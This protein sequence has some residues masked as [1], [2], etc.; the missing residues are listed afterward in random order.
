[1]IARYISAMTSGIFITLSLF[2]VMQAL[3][4]LTHMDPDPERERWSVDFGR[5]ITERPVQQR[6]PE[7][8]WE[9]LKQAPEPLPPRP[10]HEYQGATTRVNVRQPP[11]PDASDG[12]VP[13][14][15]FSDGP[16]V[17]IVRVQPSYPPRAEQQGLEGWVLVEFDVGSDG[18]VAN[19]R[20]VESS[21][22]LFEK[23]AINAA[24]KFRF[25]AR[26]VDGQPQPSRGI[27]NLFRFEIERG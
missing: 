10:Q 22:R 4:D 13:W 20:V 3:I 12:L 21:H 26:V 25:K 24:M 8:D 15:V 1:M 17:A 6:A 5:K 9:Q 27:R 23:A 16:L 14:N 2:F 7:P 19:P 11:A 18:T